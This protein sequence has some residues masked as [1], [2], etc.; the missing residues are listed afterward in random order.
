MTDASQDAVKE[1]QKPLCHNCVVDSFF[2]T[3][4]TRLQSFRDKEEAFS[5]KVVVSVT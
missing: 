3:L 2:K 1:T 5:Y 4:P